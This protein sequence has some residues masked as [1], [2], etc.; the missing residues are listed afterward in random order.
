V[1]ELKILTCPAPVLFRRARAV[2][3]VGP[4]VRRLAHNMLTTMYAASGVGLAA[5]QI[6][7]GKRLTVVDVGLPPMV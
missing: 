5:P 1:A 4:R 7:V 3:W 2:S 6:G